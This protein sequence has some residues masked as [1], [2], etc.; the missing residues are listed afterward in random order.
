MIKKNRGD[1]NRD[2]N[3]DL[4]RSDLNPPTLPKMAQNKVI[5]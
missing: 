1:L 2:L 4:N 3:H 5:T